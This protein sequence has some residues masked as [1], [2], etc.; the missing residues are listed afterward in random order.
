MNASSK[1][2]YGFTPTYGDYSLP[3]QLVTLTVVHLHAYKV[4]QQQMV[5]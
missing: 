3:T 1:T 5:L 4:L 2:P